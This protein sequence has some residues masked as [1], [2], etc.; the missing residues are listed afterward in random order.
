MATYV[1]SDIHGRLAP[2]DRVLNRIS[3]SEDDTFFVLGD[4]VDR[5]PHPVGVMQLCRT[6]PH[7]QVIMGNHERLMLDALYFPEDAT[8]AYNWGANGGESTRAELAAMELEPRI[9]IVEWVANLPLYAHT[10]VEEQL[11]FFVHAGIRTGTVAVPHTWTHES[12]E[13]YLHAQNPDDLLWI[14]EDFWGTQTNLADSKGV[15]PRI[16]AGHT[17]TPIAYTLVDVAANEPLTPEGK[18]LLM[19]CGNTNPQYADRFAIDCAC[20]AG[21]EMGQVLVWRLDDNQTFYETVQDGE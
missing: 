7:V 6:L 10:F 17:P 21:S 18:A 3:P 4:M 2:L 15:A 14:R 12:I 8:A 16:V 19:A 11:Y 1:L 5:G 20:A 9:E 13:A